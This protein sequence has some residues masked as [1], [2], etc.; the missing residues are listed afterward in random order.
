MKARLQGR[1]STLEVREYCGA[2]V[3]AADRFGQTRSLDSI[4]HLASQNFICTIQLEG[5]PQPGVLAAKAG[6]R[7]R[8]SARTR[9]PLKRREEMFSLNGR[10]LLYS[11]ERTQILGW[12]GRTI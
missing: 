6:I 7:D 1:A 3:A 8:T 5:T 12:L 11:H 9:A 4:R 10:S 2:P